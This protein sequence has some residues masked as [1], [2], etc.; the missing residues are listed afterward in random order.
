MINYFYSNILSIIIII[1]LLTL[2]EIIF[3]F[4]NF[5]K[6]I[7]V[8]INRHFERITNLVIDENEKKIREFSKIKSMFPIFILKQLLNK[9]KNLEEDANT[10]INEKY[11]VINACFL[12]TIVLFSL[13]IILYFIRDYQL[14][15]KIKQFKS[16]IDMNII[17]IIIITFTLIGL[18]QI[19]FF[20]NITLNFNGMSVYDIMKYVNESF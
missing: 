16:C 9:T 5:T 11:L 10:E 4:L 8:K 12:F 14:K 15:N 18:F 20:Y 3:F 2:F 6:T 17:Y 1:V 19:Y 13:L 7:N